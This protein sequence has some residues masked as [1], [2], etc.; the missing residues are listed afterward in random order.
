MDRWEGTIVSATSSKIQGFLGLSNS[1]LDRDI[2]QQFLR[3]SKDY[4]DQLGID[5]TSS[6]GSMDPSVKV[7]LRRQLKELCNQRG[8][9]LGKD[10]EPALEWRLYQLQRNRRAESRRLNPTIESVSES[11]STPSAAKPAPNVS[12]YDPVR[13]S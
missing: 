12:P 5:K 10:I 3:V 4:H 9:F 8:L 1:V 11:S 13:D 2:W 7:T 6:W